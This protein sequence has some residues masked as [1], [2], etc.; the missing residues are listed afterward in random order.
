MEM[1]STS[2]GE[3]YDAE[4]S[5]LLYAMNSDDIPRPTKSR[6]RPSLAE[7]ENYVELAR[8]ISPEILELEEICKNTLGFYLVL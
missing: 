1:S 7:V 3:L 2:S 4:N 5:D 6:K 8:R